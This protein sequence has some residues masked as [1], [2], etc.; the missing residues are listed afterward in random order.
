MTGDM[1]PSYA[2]AALA[3]GDII[4]CQSYVW[5]TGWVIMGITGG[6]YVDE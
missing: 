4:S 1:I 3:T 6:S 5:L 2:V